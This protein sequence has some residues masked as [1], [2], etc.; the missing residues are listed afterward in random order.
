MLPAGVSGC[1]LGANRS[2][3]VGASLRDAVLNL[4]G[5]VVVKIAALPGELILPAGNYAG[6]VGGGAK[7]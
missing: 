2:P 7:P 4:F 6:L 3:L 5:S 1:P